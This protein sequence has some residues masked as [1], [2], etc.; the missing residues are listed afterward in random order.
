MPLG[1]TKKTTHRIS[2]IESDCFG[3][4]FITL[5]CFITTIR[6]YL[7]AKTYCRLCTHNGSKLLL[8]LVAG[9]GQRFLEALEKVVQ[10]APLF[11]LRDSDTHVADSE[12]GLLD[13]LV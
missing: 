10:V 12:V 3:I 6:W 7:H 1:L 9:F 5:Y 13:L 8:A 4:I 11:V 2:R